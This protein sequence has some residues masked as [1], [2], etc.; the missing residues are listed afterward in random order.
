MVLVV[1]V[2]VL[3]FYD[4]VTSF[5]SGEVGTLNTGDYV[6]MERDGTLVYHGLATTFQNNPQAD[7]NSAHWDYEPTFDAHEPSSYTMADDN[8]AY[9]NFVVPHGI[10]GE[11]VPMA[12]I[13]FIPKDT[14]CAY[15]FNLHVNY[16]S[17]CTSFS[18]SDYSSRIYCR[19]VTDGNECIATFELNEVHAIQEGNLNIVVSRSH[20]GC[21]DPNMLNID[22]EFEQQIVGGSRTQNIG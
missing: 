17:P 14:N 13:H 22:L 21:R 3:L 4:S 11:S 18:H 10:V 6:S 7:F 20:D 9:F 5:V 2:K 15:V 8:Q 19:D 16:A 12:H 1:L